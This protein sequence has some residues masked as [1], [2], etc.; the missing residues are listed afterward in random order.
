MLAGDP[1]RFSRPGLG[2]S[3]THEGFIKLRLGHSLRGSV[4]VPDLLFGRFGPWRFF[5]PSFFGPCQIGF[6]VEPGPDVATMSMDV[7]PPRSKNPMRILVRIRSGS[8]VRSYLDGSQL[9]RCEFVGPRH[10]SPYAAGAAHKSSADDFEIELFHHT[11]PNAYASIVT[12]GRLRSSRWNLQGTRTLRNVAYVYLTSLKNIRSDEDLQRIAM[13]SNGEIKFQTTSSRRLEDVLTLVVYRENT[14]GRTSTV[15]CFVP[16]EL[17]SSPHLYFH[18]SVRFE[19]AWY[20]IVSPEIFK[21]G[22]LPGAELS[23]LRHV[24]GCAEEDRVSFDYVV[25]GD[26]SELAGLAAPY[27]EEET[28][29]V[30]HTEHLVD[31]VDFFQFW[32]ERPN[33]D[34]TTGRRPVARDL[35]PA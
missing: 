31:I 7:A 8:R 12:S 17:L 14:S 26:A 15:R 25:L 28:K 6:D 3:D 20:E 2:G 18:P 23:L 4:L 16:V 22:V 9:H 29:C 13:A 27:D 34:Q 24:A 32:R 35:D 19:P 11:T 33:S 10:M 21:V 30:M 5:Q 1:S